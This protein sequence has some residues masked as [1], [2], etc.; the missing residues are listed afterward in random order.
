[1]PILGQMDG[2][3]G[4]ED[5]FGYIWPD[6]NCHCKICDDCIEIDYRLSDDTNDCLEDSETFN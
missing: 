2:W 1:M 3:H 5:D 6:S 4:D